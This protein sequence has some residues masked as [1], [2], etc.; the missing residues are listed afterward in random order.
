MSDELTVVKSLG[1]SNDPSPINNK[2]D[3]QLVE[4]SFSAAHS[5]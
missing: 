1:V 4:T 5:S 3:R 2:F